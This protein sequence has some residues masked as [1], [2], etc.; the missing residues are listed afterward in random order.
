MT[1]S[2]WRYVAHAHHSDEIAH[3]LCQLALS[4]LGLP[5]RVLR[6]EPNP[7]VIHYYFT[8][9]LG[10]YLCWGCICNDVVVVIC[11]VS[12]EISGE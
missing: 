4:L 12:C 8:L 9:S 1:F 10:I 3:I 2:I 5:G 7:A 11:L 6:Y